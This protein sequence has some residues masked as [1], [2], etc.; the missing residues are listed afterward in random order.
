[1]ELFEKIKRSDICYVDV[2]TDISSIDRGRGA[3]LVHRSSKSYLIKNGDTFFTNYD[4]N[5]RMW[6]LTILSEEIKNDQLILRLE[7]KIV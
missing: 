4:I 1:M 6:N 3:R 2:T 5:C 7:D